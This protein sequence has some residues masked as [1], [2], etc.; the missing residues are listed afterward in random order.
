MA[1][2]LF[3]RELPW[4][5]VSSAGVAALVNRSADIFAQELML[6]QQLD[7]SHHRARQISSEICSANE[8]IFVMEN[9]H[10]NFI[11]ENFPPSRGKIFLLGHF[12]KIEIPDPY[13]QDKK[14]FKYALNLIDDGVKAWSEQIVKL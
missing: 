7:I 8:I 12:N 9:E 2:A 1:E 11:E 3:T 14:A 6:E 10:K 5:T 4:A 13:R